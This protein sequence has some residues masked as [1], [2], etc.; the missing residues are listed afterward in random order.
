MMWTENSLANTPQRTSR[1]VPPSPV[2]DDPHDGEQQTSCPSGKGQRSRLRPGA[3]E[4]EEPEEARR[5]HDRT[6]HAAHSL[7]RRLQTA[8]VLLE[9]VGRVPELPLNGGHADVSL[10]RTAHPRPGRATEVLWLLVT[11]RQ[12]RH[13][14]FFFSV[15]RSHRKTFVLGSYQPRLVACA[16]ASL[17]SCSVGLGPTGLSI[18]GPPVLQERDHDPRERQNG[19]CT[20]N[21]LRPTHHFFFFGALNDG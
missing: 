12:A 5:R 21:G 15:G 10:A 1:S 18:S 20:N 17:A 16:R 9:E 6:K 11:G 19:C 2:E 8:L 13:H 14:H 3:H 7:R 4:S